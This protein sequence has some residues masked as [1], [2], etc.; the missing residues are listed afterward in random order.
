[1]Q[2]VLPMRLGVLNALFENL[3]RLLDKLAMKI[4]GVGLDAPIG[5]I[6]AEDKLRRLL[7]VLVHLAT[8]G[9]SL[10]GQFLSP[11]AIAASVGLLR[12]CT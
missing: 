7:I 1:M 5:V 6:L 4:D 9:F 10:L 2:M 12:L 11:C 3:L 8:M